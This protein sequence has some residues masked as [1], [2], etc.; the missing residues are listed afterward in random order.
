MVKETNPAEKG[1]V[2]GQMVPARSDLVQETERAG[3]R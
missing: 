1:G 2:W 3:L